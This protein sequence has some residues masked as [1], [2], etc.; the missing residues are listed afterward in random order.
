MVIPLIVCGR[1]V[2]V[3]DID[4]VRRLRSKGI[5][6]ILTGS[7]PKAPQQ[8]VFL[9]LPLRLSMYEALWVVEQ[10]IGILVDGVQYHELLEQL[11]DEENKK[12]LT[13]TNERE[14]E[15][16]S[17]PK[18]QDLPKNQVTTKNQDL[19][20]NNNLIEILPGIEYAVT[21]DTYSLK[22]SEKMLEV[23]QKAAVNLER[24]MEMLGYREGNR[25]LALYSAF[26]TLRLQN[27]FLM[28]G[29]RFGG[30]FV[31]Y[32]GDPLKF[33]SH[34][35]VRV[36]LPEQKFDLLQLVS[37]GRLATAVKKA[38]LLMDQNGPKNTPET[39][40]ETEEKGENVRCFSIEWAGFG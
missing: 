11:V 14:L 39:V 38:W 26:S 12:T 35:I 36:L 37:C 32:P 8:N 16:V 4:H 2:L 24:L 3:F 6:G 21:R 23:Y 25:G 29:L 7:L 34:L 33:H 19:P 30:D 13:S 9:G 40:N 18:N 20:R 15:V 10:G 1:D 17:D 27:Y 22:N 31:A 5:V 28:P